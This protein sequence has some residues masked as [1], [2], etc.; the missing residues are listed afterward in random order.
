MSEKRYACLWRCYPH[1]FRE[2]YGG[3]AIQLFRD[4]CPDEKG[5][6]RQLRLWID[7]LS[8]FAISVLRE[9][10]RAPDRVACALAKRRQHGI[11]TFHIFGYG[12]PRFQSLLLAGV[13]SAGYLLVRRKGR[14]DRAEGDAGAWPIAD[15]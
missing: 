10:H 1:H 9:H 2:V 14:V 11:L 12:A 8:D 4:R 3:E 5:L 15:P 6:C 13:L 7:L